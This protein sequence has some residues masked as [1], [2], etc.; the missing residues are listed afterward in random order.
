MRI[1]RIRIPNNAFVHKFAHAQCLWSG[2]TT[3][4]RSLVSSC[5]GDAASHSSKLTS[6]QGCGMRIRIHFIRIRIQSGSR[7]LMTNFF[8]DQK[9]QFTYPQASIK[10]VQVSEE[11]FSSQ[12]RPSNTSKHE[13][14]KNVLLLW[15]IFAFLVPDPDPLTRLNPDPIRI[16]ILSGSGS[17]TLPL[18]V[19]NYLEGP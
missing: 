6:K 3:T 18:R 9:L 17:A 14:L 19:S 8:F 12:K 11:A 5:S 13:L 4:R 1:L 10:N 15:V 2:R 7:A 16:R